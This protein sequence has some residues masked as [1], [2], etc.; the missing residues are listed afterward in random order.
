V[1]GSALSATVLAQARVLLAQAGRGAVA[2]HPDGVLGV[3]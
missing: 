1:V 2:V 3:V